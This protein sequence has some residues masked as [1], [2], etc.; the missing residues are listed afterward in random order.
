MSLLDE[1]EI[2]KI[3]SMTFY[4][5]VCLC[6]LTENEQHNIKDMICPRCGIPFEKISTNT[7]VQ[8]VTLGEG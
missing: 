2:D 5:K 6:P 4:K 3:E 1:F 8:C 7:D